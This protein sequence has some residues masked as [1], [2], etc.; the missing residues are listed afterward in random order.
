MV[1][2]V[3]LLEMLLSLPNKTCTTII[4]LSIAVVVNLGP[5]DLLGL[6]LPEI[7]ASR[8]DGEGFWEL[9]SKNIWR[10]KVEDHWSIV[11]CQSILQRANWGPD[12]RNQSFSIQN[13]DSS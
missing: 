13:G 10:L 1:G 9:Q 8:G 7:L 4:M 6:Q 3:L 12:P 11:L 2:P 5:P